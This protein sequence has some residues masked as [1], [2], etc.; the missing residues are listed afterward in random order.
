MMTKFSVF[1]LF[2]WMQV[3]WLSGYPRI[4]S[5]FT[6]LNKRERLLLLDLSRNLLGGNPVIVEVGSYLGASTCFLA[7]G[8]RLRGGKVYAVDTWTNI[9]MPEEPRDTYDEFISNTRPLKNWIIPLRGLSTEVAY[10][11]DEEIDLLFVD[12]DHSYGA[13]R[14]DLDA[15]LPKLKDGG[16]VAFHDYNWAEGVRRAVRELIVPLQVEGGH[17]LGSIY[18]TRINR[19]GKQK[20]QSAIAASVI[21]PTY[22]RPRYLGEAL[23]SLLQQDF[24]SARY[25]IIVVDNKPTGEVRKLVQELEQDQRRSIRYVEEPKVGLH[26]ARHTGAREAR[27]EILVYIDDDVIVHPGWLGAVIRPFSD[28]EV[29]CVGGKVIPKWEA[30]PPDWWPELSSTYLSLLDLGEE[31]KE[32]CWPDGVYGCNM[33]VRRSALYEVGGFNPDD[34]G[35]RKL[36]W[37]RGDGET[38]LHRKIY[39]AGYKVVYSPHAWLYHRIPAARLKAEYFYQ[40]AFTQGI[41]DSYAL[42]REDPS[43]HRMIRHTVGCFLRGAGNYGRSIGNGSQNIQTRVKAWYWCGR[44]QHQLRAALDRKLYHHVLQDTY[45]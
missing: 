45:L 6:H 29:A 43:K 8:A 13:V 41:S 36:I 26:N 9:D 7:T 27:G 19:K 2:K 12:G 42:I 3:V 31:T 24:P 25:E 37:L 15:W 18:W 33:A 5:I 39:D 10:Q 16:V 14:A 32:L 17:R 23:A 30:E 11:F 34:I 28:P 44:G 1:K 22:D 35:N 40:R 4:F 38:G 20:C 21:I